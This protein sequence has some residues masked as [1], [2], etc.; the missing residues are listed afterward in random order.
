M[1]GRD[2]QPGQ[3]LWYEACRQHDVAAG[4][5]GSVDVDDFGDKRAR[6]LDELDVA[7]FH[8]PLQ[9]L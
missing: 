8:K 1:I 7:G 9:T 4:V 6:A 3:C 2:V 5:A